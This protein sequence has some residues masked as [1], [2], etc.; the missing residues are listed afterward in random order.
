MSDTTSEVMHF[1]HVLR[2]GKDL[3]LGFEMSGLTEIGN[4]WDCD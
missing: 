1:W 4:M 3:N 2:N